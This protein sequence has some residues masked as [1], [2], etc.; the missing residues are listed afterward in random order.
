M[1]LLRDGHY[2]E[3]SVFKM[4]RK[5]YKIGVKPDL[6]VPAKERKIEV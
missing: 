6:N 2:R 5:S 3:N 1:N 4:P